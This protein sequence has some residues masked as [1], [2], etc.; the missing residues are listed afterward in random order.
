MT[1]EEIVASVKAAYADVDASHITDHVAFQFNVTGE[2]E[3]AFYVE[4]K[5]GKVNVEPY[6]YYDRDILVTANAD[7]VIGL[8]N[9]K[10]DPVKAYLIGRLKA[11]G[12]LGKAAFLKQLSGKADKKKK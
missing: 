12:D 2:G 6:E 11:E 4:I 8:A 5:D 1:Y 3:G 7:T 9:G 10:I